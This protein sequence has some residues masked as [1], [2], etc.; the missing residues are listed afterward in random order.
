MGKR[1]V[2]EVPGMSHGANPIPAGVRVGNMVFSGGIMGQ[3]P[4]NGGKIPPEPEKQATLTFMNIRRLI[5]AAGG[6]TDDIAHIAVSLKDLKHR[7]LVNT[8]WIKMFPDEHDRPARHTQQYDLAGNM[9]IQCQII[10]VL[11]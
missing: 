10:A 2:I 4:D 11:D 8:E 1:K 6:T 5:E 9:L 3:D 7:D